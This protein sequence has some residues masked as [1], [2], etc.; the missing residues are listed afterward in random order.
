MTKRTSRSYQKREYLLKKMFDG[1]RALY[2][3]FENLKEDRDAN[4]RELAEIMDV[5]YRL[6]KNQQAYLSGVVERAEKAKSVVYYLERRFG[7]NEDGTFKDPHGMY[8]LLFGEKAPKIL[9]ARTYNF[10]IG[11]TK[12][13]WNHDYRGVK[14]LMRDLEFPLGDSLRTT[15]SRLGRGISSGCESLTFRM[16]V[17][18]KIEKFAKD[19]LAAFKNLNPDEKVLRAIFKGLPCKEKIKNEIVNHELRHIIDSI[20]GNEFGFFTETP[21][22]LYCG[23]EISRG[24]NRDFNN[25]FSQAKIRIENWNKELERILALNAPNVIIE[26]NN[27]NLAKAQRR[28]EDLTLKCKE[29]TMLY[30]RFVRQ[31]FTG[32]QWA[33]RETD[34]GVMSYLFSTIPRNKLFRR[35]KE[36]TFAQPLEVDLEEIGNE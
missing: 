28:L 16:P 30:N 9:E 14:T 35:I 25:A 24:L 5:R 17:D 8:S 33:Y 23:E 32:N 4:P 31:R 3:F 20:I 27:K 7:L 21:A 29:Q 19:D 26:S 15:I 18:S 13:Y 34:R 11:F 36:I 2:D 1:A 22:Y 12:G 6:T 10:G